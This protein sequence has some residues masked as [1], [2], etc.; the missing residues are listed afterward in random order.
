MNIY[1]VATKAILQCY[2]LDLKANANDPNEPLTNCPPEMFIF[3]RDHAT[4]EA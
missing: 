3:M 4:D 2:I 1:G